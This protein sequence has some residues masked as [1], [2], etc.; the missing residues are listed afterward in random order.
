MVEKIIISGF[1]G[2]GIILAGKMLAYV[3]MI[4]GKQ[5]SHI[6]SYGAEMRGG[7]ANCSVIISDEEIASPMV[8]HPTTLI[9]M[10]KPSL[11]KFEKAVVS[12]GNLFVNRSLIEVKPER[13][14]LRI[15]YVP[16]NNLAEE[17]GSGRAAN[18]VMLGAFIAATGA[19]SK[20]DVKESLPKLI[21]RRNIQLNEVNIRAIDMG[22]DFVKSL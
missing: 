13:E 7:T 15:F 3:G 20:E 22:Y 12:R 5:V 2:Q 6:P 16:A 14:D 4:E 9:V 11:A 18:M 21:S 10:N 19:V 8:P 17:A 1:G